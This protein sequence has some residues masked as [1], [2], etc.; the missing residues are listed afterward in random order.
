MKRLSS[1]AV[2]LNT[3]SVLLDREKEDQESLTCKRGFHPGYMF[4]LPR[5]YS[6]LQYKK[7]TSDQL[8]YSFSF[9]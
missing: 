2:G 9:L 8:T 3:M 1:G 4:D 6:D 7:A 5:K